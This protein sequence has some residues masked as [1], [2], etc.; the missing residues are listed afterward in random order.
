MVGFLL[1]GEEQRGKVIRIRR[2]PRLVYLP[3]YIG[4]FL[5]AGLPVAVSRGEYT[6]ARRFTGV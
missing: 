2:L 6:P 4:G 1:V 3:T 5:P